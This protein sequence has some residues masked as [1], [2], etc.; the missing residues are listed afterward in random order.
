MG[1]MLHDGDLSV[2]SHSWNLG[3]NLGNSP[4]RIYGQAWTDLRDR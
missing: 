1:L 4:A 2:L 3:C